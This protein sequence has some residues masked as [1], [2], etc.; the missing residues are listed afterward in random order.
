MNLICICKLAELGSFWMFLFPIV[1]WK[2]L[3]FAV[4][5][6]LVA[7]WISK[8]LIDLLID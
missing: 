3:Y 5:F 7:V 2:C 4:Y 8:R 6:F 1:L